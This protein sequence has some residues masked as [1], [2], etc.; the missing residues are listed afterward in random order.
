[1]IR[2]G[3]GLPLVAAACAVGVGGDVGD[4]GTSVDAGIAVAVG[5]CEVITRQARELR[6]GEWR[7]ENFGMKSS[8]SK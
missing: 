5:C 6:F 7:E 1:M 3:V 4:G 8:P 2:V